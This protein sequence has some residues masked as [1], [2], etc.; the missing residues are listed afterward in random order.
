MQVKMKSEGLANRV[1]TERKK[2]EIEKKNEEQ[3][4]KNGGAGL[5]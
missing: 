5:T 3:V 1:K 2:K 4:G